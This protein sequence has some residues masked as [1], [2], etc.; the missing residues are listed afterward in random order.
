MNVALYFANKDR[1]GHGSVWIIDASAM[2]KTL[3]VKKLKEILD[4]MNTTEF[5]ESPKG[6]PLM[7]HPQTQTE[8]LRAERQKAVYLA[9]M[10]FRYDLADIW[11]SHEKKF[12][13]ERIVI[14]LHLPDG[15]QKECAEYLNNQ[16]PP[17]THEYLFPD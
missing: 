6:I 5:F 17:I 16:S 9:Q 1:A 10:D 8:Q 13:K 15:T 14:H 7:F 2:K 4:K 12:N 11:E 3:Q